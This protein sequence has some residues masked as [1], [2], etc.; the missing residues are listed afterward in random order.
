MEQDNS[1]GFYGEEIGKVTLPRNG[2]ELRPI[3]LLLHDDG[4]LVLSRFMVF[5]LL[6]LAWQSLTSCYLKRVVSC[7]DLAFFPL[8]VLTYSLSEWKD[9]ST[10]EIQ[11]GHCGVQLFCPQLFIIVL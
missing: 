10:L 4:C 11:K 1:L 2:L 8:P 6:V 9:D 5:I 7:L 3:V